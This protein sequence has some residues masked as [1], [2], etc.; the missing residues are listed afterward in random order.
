MAAR[1][2]CDLI[3][4][5]LRNPTKEYVGTRHNVGDEVVSTVAVRHGAHFGAA[6]HNNIYGTVRIGGKDVLLAR[7]C[8]WMNESGD[9]VLPLLRAAGKGPADMLVVYDDIDLAFGRIRLRG[10]GG[11]TGGHNGMRAIHARIGDGFDRLKVGVGRPP[12]R[13][14]PAAYV[15]KPFTKQERPDVDLIIETA[16]DA[17]EAWAEEGLDATANRF[18]AWEIGKPAPA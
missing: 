14:D 1:P 6:R 9:A 16:A 2:V 13:M 12:G 8:T 3:V 5:G 11:G 10:A 18:N 7:P 4:V 15:L 17:V